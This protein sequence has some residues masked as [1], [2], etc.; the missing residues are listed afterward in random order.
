[1]ALT[2]FFAVYAAVLVTELLGD[3]TLYVVSA[4]ATRYRTCVILCGLVP[5]FM[6][7]MLAAVMLGHMVAQLSE[8]LIAGITVA[9]FLLTALLIWRQEPET[10]PLL[11][12]RSTQWRHGTFMAFSAIFFTEWGDVGQV[13]AAGLAA[14]YHAPLT[15]WLAATLALTTKGALALALGVGLRRRVRR[16][17][18]RYAAMTL[19]ITM[20]VLSALRSIR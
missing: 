3:K 10:A 8:Q 20:G 4:L 19:C 5:A 13:T 18:L 15:V 9:T 11:D 7:K 1:M 2:L 17:V 12:L 16:S 6:G 14:R